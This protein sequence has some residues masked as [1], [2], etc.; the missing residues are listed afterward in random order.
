MKRDI[1]TVRGQLAMVVIVG[2]KIIFERDYKK[3]P[4]LE[5]ACEAWGAT[6]ISVHEISRGYVEIRSCP[7]PR[8]KESNE[9]LCRVL[10]W[11]PE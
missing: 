10:E 11:L 8:M 1:A 6:E 3:W 2:G 4:D 9:A 7:L 5:N